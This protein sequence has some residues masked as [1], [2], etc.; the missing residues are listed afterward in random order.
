MYIFVKVTLKDAQRE[1]YFLN[2]VTV[3]NNVTTLM[4]YTQISQIIFGTETMN[5][6]SWNVSYGLN[7][8]SGREKM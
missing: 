3:F 5:V 4:M 1:K 7:T 2:D 8:F 6:S